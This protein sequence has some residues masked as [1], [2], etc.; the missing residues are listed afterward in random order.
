MLPK[1]RSSAYLK[2]CPLCGTLNTTS[3]DDCSCCGWRGL[4]QNDAESVRDALQ[5]IYED[6]QP[7]VSNEQNKVWDILR[8]NLPSGLLRVLWPTVEWFKETL[9]G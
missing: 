9:Y 5:R 3:K 2:R 8:R 1:G 6:A 4:F 7:Q